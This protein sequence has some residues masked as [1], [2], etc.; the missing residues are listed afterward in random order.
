MIS[1]E[2]FQKDILSFYKKEGRDLPW[3]QTT[4]PYNILVSEIMLQQTQ[5]DRVIPKY[6]A[7]LKKFPT[8]KALAKAKQSDVL[9]LWSG[10]GYNRRAL[11]L[12]RAA[13]AIM[14]KHK[15]KFP[16]TIEE[17]QTLPGVGPYTARAVATFAFNQPHVF[18][19]TNIRS[20]FIYFFFKNKKD[21]HDTTILKKIEKALYVKNPR[22]WYWALMD[23]GSMLKKQVKSLNARSAHYSKQSAFVGSERQVR[24]AVVAVLVRQKKVPLK[25]LYENLPFGAERIDRVITALEKEGFVRRM[26]ASLALV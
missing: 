14:E 9:V 17:L 5:V 26:R 6:L 4:D 12:K 21:V 22:M 24:G 19:E 15:G 8:V 18:I 20:V 7:F 25:R 1:I 10:L 13:E 16:Q 11:N 23:Y 3:R 2:Q